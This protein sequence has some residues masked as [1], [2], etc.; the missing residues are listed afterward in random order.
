[1]KK[2]G[3][4]RFWLLMFSAL[5]CALVMAFFTFCNVA[6]HSDVKGWE[7]G[8][9]SPIGF[10]KGGLSTAADI[11]Y[12]LAPFSLIASLL[13]LC[14][15]KKSATVGS[16]LATL[17][18]SAYALLQ[19]IL[20]ASDTKEGHFTL[21]I[22]YFALLILGVFSLVAVFVQEV[23]SLTGLLA[24]IYG[25]LE[26]LLLIFSLLFQE[27]FS[28]FY[29][30][31]LLPFG[32]NSYFRYTIFILSILLYYLSYSLSVGLRTLASPLPFAHLAEEKDAPPP[33]EEHTEEEE[34]DDGEDDEE[35]PPSI[36][37]ED[38]GIER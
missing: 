5:G 15:S 30:S 14:I 7:F 11:L 29:Y 38:L 33:A 32:H 22:T 27:K 3:S 37:L 1:M 35:V 10:G 18:L 36:T 24:F 6:W 13:L 25:G 8:F 17:P 21:L 31:E 28:A 23:R 9:S 12:T 19:I 4:K 16:V 20:F 34:D 26:L 2:I